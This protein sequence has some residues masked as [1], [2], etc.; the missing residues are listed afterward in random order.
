MKRNI[1][2]GMIILIT[3]LSSC[4]KTKTATTA[5]ITADLD[6]TPVTFNVDA[7]ATSTIVGGHYLINISGDQTSSGNNFINIDLSSAYAFTN[8]A[9]YTD[10]SAINTASLEYTENGTDDIDAGG[11][12]KVTILNVSSS[13]I[14]GTFSGTVSGTASH[15]FTNG[16]FNVKFE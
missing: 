9:S 16:I 8:G 1:L 12:T 5:T 7:A 11:I 3:I 10:T 6:G 13:S 14:Q 15:T 2:T 4:S